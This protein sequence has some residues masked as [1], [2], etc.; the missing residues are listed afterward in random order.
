[1]TNLLRG[2]FY[3]EEEFQGLENF[4]ERLYDLRLE[5]PDL[6][7]YPN[8]DFE[9]DAIVEEVGDFRKTCLFLAA[10]DDSLELAFEMGMAAIAIRNPRLTPQ[11]LIGV[12]YLLDF[13]TFSEDYVVENIDLEYFERVFRRFHNIPWDILETERCYVR[14]LMLED[15]DDLY[16]LY[17]YP[18]ITEYME[19]LFERKK[20]YEYQQAYIEHMYRFYEYGMWLVFK[21]CDGKDNVTWN[22]ERNGYHHVGGG[23]QLIGRAGLENR[24]YPDGMELE[25]GYAFSPD[26]W[27]RGYAIEV[28]QAILDYAAEY[29]CYERINC[30]IEPGNVRSIKLVERLG[31]NFMEE[32]DF[33]GKKMLRYVYYFE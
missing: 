14:E 3:I 10:S 9:V 1:M 11:N 31:F 15:L 30:L 26:V 16:E 33:T 5:N 13:E 25:M 23:Q 20:E 19:P 6:K 8:G 27:G 2:I 17:S 7:L 4:K 29:L 12:D 18:E 21:K 24:D 28:C 32:T 22:N